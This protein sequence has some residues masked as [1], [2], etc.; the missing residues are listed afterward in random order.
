MQH[1]IISSEAAVAIIQ[2]G[3]VLAT[4]GYGGNGVPEQLLVTLEKQFV[5]TDAPRNLTLVHATGQGDMQ[6][7]GLNYLAHHGLIRRV[8]GGYYG[9]SPKLTQLAVDGS[10]EAYNFPEGCILQ[11]YRDIAAGKPGTFSKVGLGTYID[12]RIDGGK[13]NEVTTED[14]VEVA[15]VS[16]EEWLLFFEPSQ[17]MSCSCAARRQIGMAISRSSVNRL[18]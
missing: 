6:T 14:L 11:L 4:A 10:L 15:N 7:K 8:I 16:R 9:L 12:P 18:F 2:D 3:D 5:E 13:M 1:K 17:S